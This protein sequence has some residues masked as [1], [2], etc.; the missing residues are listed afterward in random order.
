MFTNAD[1]AVCVDVSPLRSFCGRPNQSPNLPTSNHIIPRHSSRSTSR[2]SSLEERPMAENDGDEHASTK[3]TRPTV[4]EKSCVFRISCFDANLSHRVIEERLARLV[5]KETPSYQATPSRMPTDSNNITKF[6]HAPFNNR[7]QTAVVEFY[8]RPTG[9]PETR[10]L[11]DN[12]K[13]PK[14]APGWWQIMS[15]APK[16]DAH[17]HGLT[18]LGLSWSDDD[19]SETQESSSLPWLAR[20]AAATGGRTELERVRVEYVLG[21]R[22]VRNCYADFLGYSIIVLTPLSEHPYDYWRSE[23]G[24]MWV[25]DFLREE[26]FDGARILV[27][28]IPGHDYNLET[29]LSSIWLGDNPAILVEVPNATSAPLFLDVSTPACPSP[30]LDL[31]LDP[32]VYPCMYSFSA[33]GKIRNPTP[34]LSSLATRRLQRTCLRQFV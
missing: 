11:D 4:P 24:S 20:Y 26:G 31:T 2:V 9:F 7:I 12:Y 25:A 30:T 33:A 18:P 34:G 13:L 22:L 10:D 5:T 15:W 14:E 32:V 3:T 1:Q 28:G 29:E 27:W 6:H 19:P 16:A 21:W 8:R 23:N 17:F